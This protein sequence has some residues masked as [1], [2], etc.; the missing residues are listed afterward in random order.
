[1]RRLIL[2]AALALAACDDE[3][4]PIDP[5]NET[6]ALTVDASAG[7]AYV[8][9]E[10]GVAST[11][12][13]T[14]AATSSEWDM[15]FRV[16][17]VM[18][19]GGS[20]GPG[21]VAGF[22][23]C[24]NAAATNAEVIAMTDESELADFDLV[25]SA[26]IPSAEDAWLTEELVPSLGAW[27]SYNPVTHVVSAAAQN[28]YAVRTASGTSFAKL[29]V[30]DL[31]GGTQASAGTVTFAYALQSSAGAPFGDVDTFRST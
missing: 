17:S 9:F 18:L 21:G 24:Q 14:D 4:N 12:S 6:G 13:V 28:V 31:A 7:W 20:A 29:H 27:Y 30:I 2:C 22:C 8:A 16:T 15:A 19:N 11:V 23:V 5:T 25:T 3:A 26:S 10:D 1:M